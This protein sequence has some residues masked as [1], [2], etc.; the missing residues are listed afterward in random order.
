MGDVPITGIA[1]GGATNGD[2]LYVGSSL[3]L[4]A[5]LTPPET[6]DTGVGWHSSDGG[7][8]NVN[9]TGLITAINPGVATITLYG[10]YGLT[11]TVSL[12]SSAVIT[13]ITV[14]GS[15]TVVSG[16][17]TTLTATT[18]PAGVYNTG[19]TWSSS[20]TSVAT[21]DASGVVSGVGPAGTVTITARS[22]I[23]TSIT[24]TI[25][26]TFTN[27]FTNSLSQSITV[28]GLQGIGVSSTRVFY[29]V[30]GV[31]S[32]L[33]TNNNNYI[34]SSVSNYAQQSFTVSDPDI[35]LEASQQDFGGYPYNLVLRYTGSATKT[36]TVTRRARVGGFTSTETYTAIG[37]SDFGS[38]S[39][40][41]SWSGGVTPAYIGD[42]LSIPYITASPSTD[43]TKNVTIA[44][45]DPYN[46]VSFTWKYITE[47][48]STYPT[49]FTQTLSNTGTSRAVSEY[50]N[51]NNAGY[52]NIVG[53]AFSNPSIYT[54]KRVFKSSQKYSTKETGISSITVPANDALTEING[55]L[56]VSAT[57]TGTGTFFAPD[58]TF[59]SSNP[60]V[61]VTRINSTSAT[62]TA[63][64]SGTAIITATTSSG[65]YTSTRTFTTQVPVTGISSISGSSSVNAGSTITLTATV[66]PS[67]A[68]NQ[69]ITWSSSATGVATVDASGVVTG[70][71]AG[72]ATI[73]ATTSDG[74][75]TATKVITVNDAVIGLSDISGVSTVAEEM[76]IQ[77]S[78][79]VI[80]P[81]ATNPTITW[82][83]SNT[84]V[85]TVSSTGL[86]TGVSA[87]TATITA[88]T[89]DGGFT[90]TK[91]ITVTAF[92]PSIGVT[93][94]SGGSSTLAAGST[95]Q[96]GASTIPV[97]ATINTITWS[98]SNTA[99]ATV[100]STGLVTGVGAGTVYISA[101]D[102]TEAMSGITITVY[103]NVAV[104]GIS[105][106]S[107]SS[108]VNVGS[109][110]ALS[111]SVDPSGATVKTIT[112]S[113]SATGVA[114][115]DA[116]GVVTGVA[117]GSATITATTSN[118]GFTATKVI[119]VTVP[120]VPVTG[121]S[122]S[123]SIFTRAI[124]ETIQLT[125]TISPNGATNS[126]VSWSSSNE[127][128]ATVDASGVVTAV[129]AGSVTIT[130]T[131]SDGSFTA[132]ANGTIVK[133]VTNFTIT[134]ASGYAVLRI[135]STLQ[136]STDNTP[137]D[138]LVNSVTWS[139]QD[140]SVA[141]IDASGL[142]T[143]VA[144]SPDLLVNIFCTIN[145]YPS[146]IQKQVQLTTANAFTGF[147]SSGLV[148]TDSTVG[149]VIQRGDEININ[150]TQTVSFAV[151]IPQGT[152][153]DSDITYSSS[154]T[155]VL[156][157]A[158]DKGI[159]LSDTFQVVGTGQTVISASA[160]GTTSTRTITVVDEQF[161]E[162]T[163]FT[164]SSTTGSSPS[165]GYGSTLQLT[166]T[167]LPPNA[168][169]SSPY[170]ELVSTT[171]SGASIDRYTGIVTSGSTDG[172]IVVRAYYGDGSIYQPFT[173]AVSAPPVPVTSI[174]AITAT[175]N[176][177][178]VAPLYTL[179][180]S[181]TIY[182]DDA[183]NNTIT[184][185]SSDTTKATV[186]STGLV[187]GVAA[188]NLVTITATAA[189]NTSCFSTYPLRIGVPVTGIED[190]SG[191][192]SAVKGRTTQLTTS[193]IPGNATVPDITWTSSDTAVATVN[194]STGAVTAVEGGT[195]TI[196]ATSVEG[197]FTKTC[198]FTTVILPQ[199]ITNIS[200]ASGN[201][202]YIRVP[203]GGS[204]QFSGV[205]TPL[206]TT[207]KALTWQSY[208]TN[209]ATVDASGVVTGVVKGIAGIVGT[210]AQN[211][212]LT[213]TATV[214]VYAPVTGMNPITHS[215]PTDEVLIGASIDISCNGV[216]PSTAD[217][218]TFTWSTSHPTHVLIT[219]NDKLLVLGSMPD[220]SFSVTVTSEDGGFTASKD[221][222]IYR[223]VT[224]TNLIT[225]P[226]RASAVALNNTLQLTLP[227]IP[228][229]ATVQTVTWSSSNSSK[230]SV[231]A[232][233]VC[234]GTGLTAKKE[235]VTITGSITEPSTGTTY[236]RTYGLTVPI[237][238][239]TGLNAITVAGSPSVLLNGSSYQLS[240]AI[241]P[242]SASYA[243]LGYTWSLSNTSIAN[244]T[245][246]GLLTITGG[247]KSIKVT[248]TAVGE[249]AKKRVMR[250]FNILTLPTSIVRPVA[251]TSNGYLVARGKKITLKPVILPADATNKKVTYTSNDTSKAT[252]TAA[253]GTITGVAVG[254]VKIT[255]TSVLN[256]SVTTEVDIT[257]V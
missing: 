36:F 183:T 104:T 216:I 198:D 250:T 229:N 155:A 195:T 43:A 42:D 224:G 253:T 187:T 16:F 7:I 173:V 12:I 113:S 185:T 111:A 129:S 13:G 55:S 9:E 236:T 248:A 214:E 196:T 234:T 203:V 39:N 209:I 51:N 24:G 138:G 245:S 44:P 165:L 191:A 30:L 22:V 190:I 235:V 211:P 163:G 207:N 5:L 182:P 41:V 162:L 180:L 123:D 227:T 135:G 92:I 186:S 34:N 67:G 81:G 120:V 164:V 212:A 35:S 103:A 23:N 29:G 124:D 249:G 61:T 28:S 121:V 79:S 117:G 192:S 93:D 251:T 26:I 247:A 3:Q 160:Y 204:K 91:P 19:V 37:S 233:G 109:T 105:S 54:R 84:G 144:T 14:S 150:R 215:N 110:I 188:T 21:V 152:G 141:T 239:I 149:G 256:P 128:V 107:G 206:N 59:T 112:W 47:G 205:F 98:S 193:V 2:I 78:A 147:T 126:A 68:N 159:E 166:S 89:A 57:A 94:I 76:T 53:V 122:L 201:M 17:S 48:N 232:S 153:N 231:D 40:T 49:K 179:Q 52:V 88:T 87:G 199:A 225:A 56:V 102:Y 158:T 130:A 27:T 38:I 45:A 254:A 189:G 228:V 58:V 137:F 170:W 237:N 80:P 71:L 97:D 33:Q 242:S 116:S 25:T 70:V 60:C 101:K 134:L 127:A 139:S 222:T 184:W 136:L 218:K 146:E 161:V 241:V 83:S 154:N 213:R 175:S 106:I 226:G 74:G 167:P 240:S 221:F 96:L 118:G 115:V 131:T 174:S 114:T 181:A 169:Y 255:I 77:L 157:K 46:G 63:V 230:V 72:S 119:T 82:S 142:V 75:Y 140:T 223:P 156:T 151:T 8:I 177:T 6:T 69:T 108:S 194:A 208:R 244:I 95:M 238:K 99:V 176:L 86:V 220:N 172:E 65:S 246:G 143:C 200:D 178:H 20:N 100:S 257:V 171:S 132:I 219:R 62:L 11:A 32:L 1:I 10:N 243:S 90:K 168:S 252:V 64:S 145:T 31:T 4:S 125:A 85:A 217:I 18:L 15:T 50:D 66:D 148:L 202:D 197:A 210:S 73:T 133:P